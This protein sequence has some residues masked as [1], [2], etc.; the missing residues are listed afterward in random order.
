[1]Q[2]THSVHPLFLLGGGGLNL[3]PNF[4]KGELEKNK[5]KPEIFNDKKFYKEK[6]ISLS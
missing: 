2:Y 6:Y 1:M 3:Q 4:Q 5:L